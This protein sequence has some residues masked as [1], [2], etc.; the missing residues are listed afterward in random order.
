MTATKTP[1]I[2]AVKINQVAIAVK[3]VQETVENYW[4][5]LGIGPWDVF[6]FGPPLMHEQTYHGKPSKHTFKAAFAKVGDI[7]LELIQPLKGATTHGDFID[8]YG[9]DIHHIRYFAKT[10]D[11]LDEHVRF[12]TDLGYPSLMGGR[13]GKDGAYCCLDTVD[14]L[15]CILE[16]VK[17]PSEMPNP[18]YRWPKNMEEKSP[19]K[20]HIGSISQVGQV[21]PDLD[22]TIKN[23]WEILGIGPWNI[24]TC[25]PPVAHDL[26][27][28]DKPGKYT[29]KAAFVKA[30]D[31]E[32]E[33]IEPISGKN[34]YFDFLSEHGGGGLHHIQFLVDDV[35][36]THKLMEDSGFPIMMSLG[37]GDGRATYFDTR[38]S[39]KCIWEMLKVPTIELPVTVY[40]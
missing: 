40:P 22:E 27:Y 26:T 35:E 20:I 16:V 28:W 5:K 15:K 37:F 10:V 33:P 38:D 3:D 1:P 13:F 30:G 9:E 21:V 31:L 7:E 17:E 8:E 29:M 39:L 4:N 34:I 6:T 32:I 36:S 25:V 2:K 19:A 11:E 14:S 24:V 12:L 18:D 23:Y